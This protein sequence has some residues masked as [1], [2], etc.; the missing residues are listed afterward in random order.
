MATSK[1]YL[2]YATEQFSAVG[3]VSTR[4]MMGEYVLYYKGK[5]IGGIY[6]SRILIKPVKAAVSMMND[7]E[8]QIPYQ[9]AKPM[10]LLDD[11]EN[12]EFIKSLFEAMYPELPE[13]KKR[14]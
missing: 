11:I 3:D 12:S 4:P 10:I 1:E 5:V 14:K 9:G 2:E 8:Y 13:P 7:A 6:D